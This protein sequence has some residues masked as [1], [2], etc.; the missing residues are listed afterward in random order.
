MNQNCIAR[1]VIIIF[2][3]ISLSTSYFISPVDS[4]KIQENT[5]I[6]SDVYEG[7]PF[8][9]IH[10]EWELNSEK[11]ILIRRWAE[12]YGLKDKEVNR[13]FYRNLNETIAIWD[14][15][16]FIDNTLVKNQWFVERDTE[17]NKLVYKLPTAKIDEN[18]TS[19]Y[20]TF[21]LGDYIRN[22]HPN[23]F[24]ITEEFW[25]PLDKYNL[26][27]EIN[28]S[29]TLVYYS[30]KIILPKTMTAE[31]NA[32]A[33]QSTFMELNKLYIE[34]Y[35]ETRNETTKEYLMSIMFIETVARPSFEY[36]E[37]DKRVVIL[38]TV[39]MLPKNVELPPG[40]T[41]NIEFDIIILRPLL[42]KVIFG[43]F[44]LAMLI[45]TIL[46]L[47]ERMSKKDLLVLTVT[48]W[49]FQ[50]GLYQLLPSIRPYCI[51]LFDLTLLIPIVILSIYFLIYF[52]R[53]VYRYL[54][55]K[56]YHTIHSTRKALS[57]KMH[58]L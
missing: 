15:T 44:V 25:F 20:E 32:S 27:V 24:G 16:Q 43:F 47:R 51:T 49:T 41:G 40:I 5:T 8:I 53:K 26:R 57:E 2:I 58:K 10:E 39:P 11:T 37:G 31:Y 35:N 50:E 14:Y 34:H 9:S 22:I 4:S 54:R 7:E 45:A 52:R 55:H 13:R 21:Y 42:D 46:Y 29:Q 19:L 3:L 38:P 1:R 23:Y 18:R 12:F 28:R 48:F 6:E 56:L 17:N 33:I 30:A 36:F